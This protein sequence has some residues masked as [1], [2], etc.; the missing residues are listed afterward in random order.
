M[1]APQGQKIGPAGVK[2]RRKASVTKQGNTAPGFNTPDPKTDTPKKQTTQLL[3]SQFSSFLILAS[4]SL[5]KCDC[6]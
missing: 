2:K 3:M 6:S 1:I 4:S 5:E